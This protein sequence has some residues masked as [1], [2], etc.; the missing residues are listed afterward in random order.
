MVG[1]LLPW[2][3][4]PETAS[5]VAIQ[6]HLTSL[7]LACFFTLNANMTLVLWCFGPAGLSPVVVAWLQG[8]SEVSVHPLLS[9][10]TVQRVDVRVVEFWYARSVRTAPLFCGWPHGVC[11]PLHG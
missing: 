5:N 7:A 11:R 2:Q 6:I 9:L 10:S 8:A 1:S 4:A 3:L